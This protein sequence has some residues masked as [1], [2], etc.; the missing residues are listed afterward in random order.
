MRNRTRIQ[1][2]LPTALVIVSSVL[3]TAAACGG[4][5]D[6][7]GNGS[8][9]TVAVP[10]DKIDTVSAPIATGPVSR[11][12]ILLEDVGTQAYLTDIP[13]TQT[14]DVASYGKTAAF[15]SEGEGEKLLKQW[16]YQGGYQTALI[17]EGR[18]QAPLN[19]GYFIYVESHL[20]KDVDGADAMYEHLV[21][22][23][24]ANG[25]QS[26]NAGRVGNESSAWRVVS[27][28]IRG[29]TIAQAY[30]RL[31][32][33]RGNV[34]V[35]VLTVGADPF[36]KVE[37]VRGLALEVDEKVLGKAE[38]IAPTPTSNFTPPADRART[39]TPVTQAPRPTPTAAR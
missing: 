29:S 10:G 15:S 13:A 27:G 23:I 30:H 22:R 9:G 34:V 12:S 28:F 16:G 20:L 18:E 21:S 4:D 33:R 38:A 32:F 5:D 6:D 14:L 24:R 26:V 39:P 37:T 31:V 17:P 19:G 25:G 36:M 1:I 8:P 35:V 11:F 3:A 7:N 2:L